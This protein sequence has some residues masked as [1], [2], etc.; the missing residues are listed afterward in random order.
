LAEEYVS[1]GQSVDQ[2]TKIGYMGSTGNSTGTH[3]HFE[4]TTAEM[5]FEPTNTGLFLNPT[6]VYNHARSSSPEDPDP[7]QNKV[8]C[9][10]TGCSVD[11]DCDGYDNNKPGTTTCDERVDGDASKQTCS[12]ICTYGF[13][14]GNRCLCASA[15]TNNPTPTTDPSTTANCLKMD[16]NG[17]SLLNY[18]DLQAFTFIYNKTCLNDTSN[19]DPTGCGGEDFN[20]DKKI[21]YKDLA[22]LVLNYSPRVSSCVR[23]KGQ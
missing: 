6:S 16:I 14:D 19:I 1:V 21:D 4:I 2:N 18:I 7:P 20:K 17:D 13:V 10:N 22:A 9:G 11:S 12:R 23:M 15:P 3:L 5:R 8:S